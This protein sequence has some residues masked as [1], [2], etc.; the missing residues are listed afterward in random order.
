MT[1]PVRLGV[2][3]A[4]A[5]AKYG[6]F[7]PVSRV[8]G[9]EIVAVGARDAARAGEY[10]AENGIPRGDTYQ[11]LL[12]DPDIEAI[13]VALPNSLHCE[14]TVKALEAGKAV[15]CEKPLASN[16]AEARIMAEAAA[17]TGGLLVE[18]V[19]WLYHPQS[20]RTK[21]IVDAGTLGALREIE[22]TFLVPGKY[23]TADDIRFSTVLSGGATMDLGYYAISFLRFVGGEPA[24][25][26]AVATE[27]KPGIDGTMK[28][29]MRFPG[30]CIGRMDLS[31]NYDADDFIIRAVIT[32]ER[33]RM[34]LEN[35]VHPSRGG[36]IELE[37]D[38]VR[39]V[40]A[41][42]SRAT[43]DWQALAFAANVREGTPV[44][45]TAEEGI[46]NMR[47]ID[48]VY[49]AAGMKPRGT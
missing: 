30:G 46:A 22:F 2:L 1:A 23:F 32:G 19:H 20:P 39:T 8:G 7:A 18:A 6:L 37:I 26:K 41:P 48:D 10:A 36:G 45:T 11:A 17:R 47:V 28:A 16:E 9:I 15:L 33:G 31:L 44:L 4:G 35:P 5:I 40:E 43:Y 29:E 13:Y 27:F 24:I 14:W 42:H 21:E 49:R 12:D 34:I 3:G 38:G 25:A